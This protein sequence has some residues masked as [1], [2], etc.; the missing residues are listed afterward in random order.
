MAVPG[1]RSALLVCDVQNGII[2]KQFSNDAAAAEAYIERVNGAIAHAR[3]Q[4][5]LLIFVR[6]AFR[7]GHPEVGDN[8]KV[9]TYIFLR[10]GFQASLLK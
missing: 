5:H 6:V 8:N 2:N 4:N 7:P 10:P 3:A 1:S 9:C